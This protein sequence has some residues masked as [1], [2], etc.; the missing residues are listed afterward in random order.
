MNL[1]IATPMYGGLAHLD[2]IN[3]LLDFNNANIKFTFMGLANESLITRARNTC[4]SYFYVMEEYSHLVFIDADVGISAKGLLKILS[5]DKDVMGAAVPIKRF[6]IN[7]GMSYGVGGVLSRDGDL[8]KVDK[9]STSVFILNRKAVNSLVEH[10]KQNDDV[11]TLKQN[12]G[13]EI[14]EIEHYDVFKV[15]IVDGEYLGEDYYLCTTL[16]KLGYDIFIDSSVRTVHNGNF[17]F[18]DK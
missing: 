4:I 13:G 17:T 7:G 9:L 16:Q 3:S 8:L 11:Y 12:V 18:G 2:F 5:Y 6:I 1:L 14:R 15:G 10:A